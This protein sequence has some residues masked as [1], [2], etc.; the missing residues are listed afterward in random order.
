VQQLAQTH[1]ITD[2][3]LYTITD[4]CL[5]TIT[6]CCLYTITDCCLHTITD[7]CL[8]TI[9]DCCYDTSCTWI[10]TTRAYDE[11]GISEVVEGYKSHDLPLHMLVMDMDWHGETPDPGGEPQGSPLLSCNKGWGGYTWNRSL[12]VDPPLTHHQ[13]SHTTPG[14]GRCLL[15]RSSSNTKFTTTGG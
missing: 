12:F 3:C 1:T 8:H 13:H 4:C 10:L 7:C 11:A 5:Y 15:T 2:C 14:T 9:T 6:D